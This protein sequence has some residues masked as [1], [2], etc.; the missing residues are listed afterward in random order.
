MCIRDSVYLARY[1]TWSGRRLPPV[2]Q[3]VPKLPA[4]NEAS[5]IVDDIT[6]GDSG[7][8]AIQQL[9]EDMRT[10][11]SSAHQRERSAKNGLD[12][13]LPQVGCLSVHVQISIYHIRNVIGKELSLFG[14]VKCVANVQACNDA[15]KLYMYASTDLQIL[16][17]LLVEL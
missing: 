9:Y 17:C 1:T 5:V 6:K 11:W 4:V 15:V 10:D 12:R 3:A 7:C 14:E 2:T 13:T 8:V 16:C